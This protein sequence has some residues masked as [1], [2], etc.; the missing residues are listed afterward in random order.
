MKNDRNKNNPPSVAPS[1]NKRPP[2]ALAK[3]SRKKGGNAEIYIICFFFFASLLFRKV[4]ILHSS[5]FAAPKGFRYVL[6][7]YSTW[8]T[9]FCSLF[10]WLSVIFCGLFLGRSTKVWRRQAKDNEKFNVSQY[11]RVFLGQGCRLIRVMWCSFR[12]LQSRQPF[13]VPII[14]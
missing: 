10:F 6:Y 13:L 12:R 1:T 9:K 7:I 14:W 2:P 11:F 8:Y 4:L 5:P 3:K